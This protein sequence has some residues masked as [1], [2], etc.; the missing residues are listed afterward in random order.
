MHRMLFV[1]VASIWIFS[2][3]VDSCSEGSIQLRI[4][5]HGYCGT[6]NQQQNYRNDEYSHPTLLSFMSRDL[7]WCSGTDVKQILFESESL[8][9]KR[10]IGLRAEYREGQFSSEENGVF[11]RIEVCQKRNEKVFRQ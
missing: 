7:E 8:I 9:R 1:E 10:K 2:G 6:S 11:D 4:R 3:G 5:I